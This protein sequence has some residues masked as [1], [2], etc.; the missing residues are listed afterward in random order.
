MRVERTR[1]IITGVYRANS[2]RKVWV[3][4]KNRIYYKKNRVDRVRIMILLRMR[5]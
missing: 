5:V 2:I 1:A 4:R 3:R